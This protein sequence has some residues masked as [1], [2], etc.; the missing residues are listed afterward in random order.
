[1]LLFLPT[2]RRETESIS[3][4]D[5]TLTS[6]S[7]ITP[8]MWR[9]TRSLEELSSTGSLRLRKILNPNHLFS[10][11]TEVYFSENTLLFPKSFLWSD[12]IWLIRTRMFFHSLW[13]CRG[14]W[15][16]SCQPRW[17]KRL[18]QSIFLESRCWFDS[19]FKSSMYLSV[20]HNDR[21]NCYFVMQWPMFCSWIPP[22]VLDTHTLTIPTIF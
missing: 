5:R 12:L 13:R 17:K 18:P 8:V 9:S 21:L 19:F 10:G 22:L 3:Y 11:L 20:Y 1:M 15:T 6:A 14:D 4:L 2:N 7:R 16:F